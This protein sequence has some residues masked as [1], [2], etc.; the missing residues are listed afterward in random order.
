M[1]G[2]TTLVLLVSIIVLGLFIWAQEMWRA[3]TSYREL[4]QI[5]LFNIDAA[6]LQSIEFT[7]SNQTVRCVRENGVWLAGEKDGSMGAADEA[8]IQRMIA[9]LNSLGKGT[10]I[11]EKQLS[12]RGLDPAEYGFDQPRAVIAAVDHQGG[13]SWLVGK[14]SALGEMVYA[15]S[16][17]DENIYTIPDK[18]LDVIPT[19]PDTLRD[20]ILFPGDAASVRRVEMR[21][22]NGFVQLVKDPKEGWR[23]RQTVNAPADPKEVGLFISKIYSFR[24]EEFIQDNVSDFSV[25]GLQGETQQISVSQ[26]DGASRL[27]ILG[28]DNPDKPGYVYARRADVASVFT[29]SAELRDLSNVPAEQF[30]D[31]GVLSVPP[32]SISSI[33]I[34]HGEDQLRMEYDGSKDWNITRP[35]VWKAE[36]RMISD[37]VTLWVNAVIHEFEVDAKVDAPEWIIEF[38][39]VEVGV[40]NRLDI[41]STKGNKSGLLVRIDGEPDLYRINLPVVPDTVIDPLIYKDRKVWG[42]DANQVSRLSLQRKS[43]S[44]Q[45]IE[46]V[47]DNRFI[48]V[49]TNGNV[50]VNEEGVTRLLRG[51]RQVNT[52]GYITYN[53]RD[54]DIY[55]LEDP[56]AELHIG[57]SGTNQLG[58]VLLIGRETPEGYYSMVKGRDVVFFL[59]KPYIETLTSDLLIETEP[60]APS[61]E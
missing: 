23:V 37:F 61:P 56:V 47:E 2:R 17:A 9:G 10:T 24:I 60:I 20:R 32:N 28:I 34:T 4:Q 18:L 57:L 35:V 3:K 36:P 51:L 45:T 43:G 13:H 50:R 40:T 26:A 22:S 58:R 29:V 27:L 30:R 14:K 55:G 21:G 8:L 54:L 42:L 7:V 41:F 15:Q 53:P 12:I 5:R 19:S 59:D 31:A 46:R 6:T 49:E 52:S 39:S 44:R 1:K 38:G 25:Y 33:R 48:P 16:S 11:T